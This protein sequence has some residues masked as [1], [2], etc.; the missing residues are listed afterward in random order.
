MEKKIGIYVDESGNFEDLHDS[1]RYCVLALVFAECTDD[2]D[3][4]KKR[5]SQAIFQ[6]GADPEAMVFHTSPLIRQEDQFSA[7][8]RNM[9]GKIFYQM[10]S[11]VRQSDL[12]FRCFA[13]DTKYVSTANQIVEI[14]QKEIKS[15]FLSSH[16]HFD[17]YS[18]GVLHYDA[19]QKSVTRILDV[20][21]DTCG[22][23]VSVAQGVRQQEQ[24]LLQVADFVCTLKLMEHRL[25]DRIPFNA[26]ETKFF[27]SPRQFIRNVMRKIRDKEL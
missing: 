4:L 24:M 18:A 5:Y 26:S 10:L 8:S 2:Y 1:A 19:G 17:S 11:F 23:P 22:F 9:R 16:D 7:M 25:K 13:V 21:P 27:G 15:F 12:R 3:K 20:I 6:I 14:L